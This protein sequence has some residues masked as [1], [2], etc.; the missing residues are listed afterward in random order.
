MERSILC[1]E[2][3]EA[4]VYPTSKEFTS[5]PYCTVTVGNKKKK[6]KVLRNTLNP[7]W[8]NELFEFDVDLNDLPEPTIHLLNWGFL[9]SQDLGFI[10]L[11]LD[12]KFVDQEVKDSWYRLETDKDKG[13]KSEVR[14]R[15]K[16]F[17]SD[18]LRKKKR[19]NRKSLIKSIPTPASL[20][21]SAVSLK[22]T[23]SEKKDI[24]SFIKDKDYHGL[25]QFLKTATPEEV[26]KIKDPNVGNT[27]LHEACLQSQHLEKF[28]IRLLEYDG[29]QVD[30]PNVDGNTPLHYFCIKWVSPEN[31]QRPLELFLKKGANINAVNNNGETPLFR[32]IYNNS[33][34]GLLIRDLLAKGA[35]PNK[36]SAQGDNILHYAARLIGRD[37][38]LD[39]ILAAA[40]KLNVKGA[41]GKTP[42]ELALAWNN[43]E[44]AS[45]L[46]KAE[47]L[48]EWLDA[49]D[50]GEFKKVFIKHHIELSDLLS[51]SESQLS[52]ME[53][54]S[55][56]RQK[57]LDACRSNLKELKAK[58]R[59]PRNSNQK[60]TEKHTHHHHHHLQQQQQQQQQQQRSGSVDLNAQEV[61]KN[62]NSS[63]KDTV[64]AST[65]PNLT[66]SPT[67]TL[68]PPP[69][70]S[71]HTGISAN[72]APALSS[73]NPID[74]L[75]EIPDN[76]NSA[77][78]EFV[79]KLGSG[80]SGDVFKGRYRGKWV[81]F[82]L[83]RTKDKEVENFLKEWAIMTAINHENVVKL[84]GVSK[85]P[86]LCMVMEYCAR[87]SLY[88][89]LK[90]ETV[91]ITWE[92][93]LDF[94]KQTA[95]GLM[96][97]HCAKPNQILHRDLK[98]LN[99]LVT[100]QWQIKV[101][102]FGL[103]RFDTPE[104]LDTM[105]QMRGTLAYC[106]PEVYFGIRFTD[107]SDIYSFGI[108]LW[109]L[110]NR[111]IK[112][113]YEQP[114]SE[115]RHLQFDF[116]IIIQAAKQNLRPTIPPSCPE[117]FANLIRRCLDKDA[118][119]RPNV[120]QV[121]DI[122]KS[123]EAEYNANKAAWEATRAPKTDLNNTKPSGP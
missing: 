74:K 38:L 67:P 92:R 53:I 73:S 85:H 43:P 104:N 107:K 13:S 8:N 22:S 60:K 120:I 63:S 52:S 97:L 103:S 113:K 93:V 15:L 108:I 72:T 110:A 62:T 27:A 46:Q 45:R 11:K 41:E 123:I 39:L 115:Y 32:A 99:L 64:T 44:I 28:V 106:C 101:A 30:V 66:P 49:H 119:A 117:S 94:A 4:K 88:N 37:D 77:E 40:P 26:N 56:A 102:D 68:S 51:L 87:G 17:R 34:R 3:V 109:E 96:A 1:I 80:A 12:R 116:Q 82:K 57:I 71:A 7:S 83:L 14:I 111:C 50:L 54:E 90:D 98:T 122:L 69:V 10:K 47:D 75:Q 16:L 105:C 114:Y 65:S 112:N 21:G 118:D 81:A 76:I 5:D 6:T 48:F 19:S 84:L 58:I 25:D 31:Y 29:I 23:L 95:N 86:K 35:D 33:I 70:P 42:K 121:L 20:T 91:D 36:T 89:V 59:S 55:D 18:S 100:D 24:F 61:S 2:I 78:F 9:G 79:E